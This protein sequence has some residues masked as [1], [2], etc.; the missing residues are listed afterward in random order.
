[1]H[2]G[3]RSPT[4]TP[5]IVNPNPNSN[6][7][8]NRSRKNP[9]PPQLPPAPTVTAVRSLLANGSLQGGP[10]VGFRLGLGSAL[11]GEEAVVYIGER[12]MFLDCLLAI[13]VALGVLS[14]WPCDARLGL[15]G[16]VSVGRA[17]GMVD[18]VLGCMH[19]HTSA[20]TSTPTPT[21]TPTSA[22][23][24]THT[25]HHAHA[26]GLTPPALA[27]ALESLAQ[28][29]APSGSYMVLLLMH[30]ADSLGEFEG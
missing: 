10:G 16:A 30:V 9:N 6:P 27:L 7:N 17:R 23:A 18:F 21:P 8:P 14:E 19:R 12:A 22:H 3:M 26:S 20:S 11:E 2:L 4:P 29:K 28:S 5:P 13:S 25:H 15:G 1:M 24:H